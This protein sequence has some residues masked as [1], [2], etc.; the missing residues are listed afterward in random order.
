MEVV[1]EYSGEMFGRDLGEIE[2]A[3]DKFIG[4]QDTTLEFFRESMGDFRLIRD[5]EVFFLNS[6]IAG[7][8]QGEV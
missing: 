4:E 3:G 2:D 1:F 6:L 7:E 8:E 5:G